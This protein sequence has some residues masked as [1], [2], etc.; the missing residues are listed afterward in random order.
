MY[1]KK[2]NIIEKESQIFKGDARIACGM[3]ETFV[4]HLQR[5]V[6]PPMRMAMHDDCR[7]DEEAM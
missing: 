6:I 4:L 7:W 2:V 1:K 3:E 5:R